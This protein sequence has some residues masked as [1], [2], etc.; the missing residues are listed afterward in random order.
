[1]PTQG[2]RPE[3]SR[4]SSIPP[5]VVGPIVQSNATQQQAAKALERERLQQSNA[6]DAGNKLSEKAADT[7]DETGSDT[8]V[9]ADSEG[10]G[11][12]GRFTGDEQSEKKQEEDQPTDSGIRRDGDGQLHVDLE[13]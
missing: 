1:M 11:S 7:V 3:A 5:N 4:M 9:D 12:Q 8:R 13:A 2:V 6:V 10:A